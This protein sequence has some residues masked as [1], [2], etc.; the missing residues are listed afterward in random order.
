MTVHRL[1]MLL[2]LACTSSVLAQ[3]P[4]YDVVIANGRVIDPESRLDATR[5]VGI[6][7][8]KIEAISATPIAGKTVLDARGLVV[9]PG[10]IDLHAHGQD[11]ENYR[12]FALEGVTTALELEVGTEDVPKFYKAREGK[13]LINYGASVGHVRARLVVMK[14]PSTSLLPTGPG[15]HQLASDA[16]IADIKRVID[17]GLAE[18]GLGVGMG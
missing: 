9:A 14:D 4:P 5:F 17:A 18:G 3:Q 13:A 11:D 15:A 6:R 1:A 16:Q 12:V 8:G 2:V 7:N 10:F